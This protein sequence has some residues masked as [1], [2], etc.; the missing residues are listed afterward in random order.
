MAGFVAI[1]GEDGGGPVLDE[2][3]AALVRNYQHLRGSGTV[4]TQSAGTWARAAT[5][6]DELPVTLDRDGDSWCLSVGSMYAPGSRCSAPPAALDGQFAAVRYAAERGELEVITDPFGMQDL[7]IASRGARTYVSTSALALARHLSA[8]PDPLGMKLFLRAGV[9]FGPVTH[10]RGVERVEPA[11]SVS[12][13]SGTRPRHHRYWMPE[14]DDRVSGLS[15][16]ATIDRCVEAGVGLLA[17]RLPAKGLISADITGGFDSRMVTT[18]L[19]RAKVPFETLTVAEEP[20]DERFARVVA[21]TAG[22]P[23][24]AQTL[25]AGWQ[26]DGARLAQALGW[27][28]GRLDVLT[29]AEVLWRQEDRGARSR[30]V[31]TGGGGENFGPSPWMQELWRAGRSRSVNYDNLMNMRVFLPLDVSVLVS[32]P[33]AD[34]EPYVREVLGRRADPYQGALN[35]TQLDVIHAYREV[36]H[37]GAYRSAGEAYVRAELPCYFRDFWTVAFSANHRWRNGHRL[38]RGIIER[39]HPAVA[40]V[41]TQR[42]GPAELVTPRNAVRF[43]PYYGRLGRTALRKLRGRNTQSQRP[44]SKTMDVYTSAVDGLHD[45]GALRHPEMLSGAFYDRA[46]LDRLVASARAGSVDGRTLL[47]RIATVELA[48][49]SAQRA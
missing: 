38:H 39:L 6:E 11:T 32:D 25:P 33:R 34:A 41:E 36:G 47:G 31:L 21:E 16:R 49:R 44:S 42:G 4:T 45:S 18:L 8:E 29:L 14:V 1:V 9:Q 7:Y 35:T 22:W 19:D 13:G 28:D 24:R 43:A 20:A 27:A 12:F 37:F 2:E 15:L 46:R 10:W 48:L 5:V 3:I 30:H 26:L 40:S 23:F 17:D